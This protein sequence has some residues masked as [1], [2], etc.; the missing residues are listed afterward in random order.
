MAA[1]DY[2]ELHCL[3]NFSFLRGASHP[4]ELVTRAA[5]LGYAALAITDECSLAGIV[6]AWEAAKK[7]NMPLIIG[8]EFLLDDAVRD[9]SAGLKLVLLAE[10]H[11]GY[12]RLCRLITQARRRS[13]K[14][15]YRIGRGDFA[16]MQDCTALWIPGAQIDASEADWMRECFG[17]AGRIAL[18]LHRGPDD[19]ARLAALTELS[20][21]CG[22]PLVAAGDVHMHLRGRR[23]LQDTVTAIRHRC[24]L[25]QAGARLFAN[26]ERHLR[27]LPALRK[28]YPEAALR[29]TLAVAERCRFQLGELRYEY[30]HE[31]VPANLSPSAFLRQRTFEGAGERWPAG[32]PPDIAALIEKELVL[33]AELKYEHYFLTVEDLVR[34]A[35]SRGILCQGRGSAAN[36]AVCYALGVTAVDPHR[37]GMLFERF[38]SKE[39][40]EPPDIDVDFEH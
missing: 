7:V 32:I 38:V 6:R 39:R 30:P 40:A 31:L 1:T 16:R 15:R 23:V 13:E 9:T 4:D 37:I 11:D 19:A 12:S 3:S 5:A 29:E 27:A 20:R 10:N 21:R 14:G 22:L 8:A 33:I 2:A 26:G 28:L 34:Y 36:S 24:T 25:E 35:R 17:D 18:E